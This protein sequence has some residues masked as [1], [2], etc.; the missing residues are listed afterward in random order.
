MIDKPLLKYEMDKKGFNQTTLAEKMD[1]NKKTLN[2]KIN[3]VSEF[4]RD[5]ILQIQTILELSNRVMMDIFFNKKL[6]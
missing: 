3:G 1:L 2:N 6:A 4:D 5:E